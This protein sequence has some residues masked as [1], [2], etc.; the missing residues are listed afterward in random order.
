MPVHWMAPLASMNTQAASSTMVR[1]MTGPANASYLRIISMPK[2]T[3]TSCTIHSDTK[4]IQPSVD[5]PRMELVSSSCSDGTMATS[6][7]RSTTEARKVWMPNQATATAPRSRL[8]SWAP[9]MPKL[10]RLMT[11]KGTPVFWP[12]NP[13]KLSSAKSRTAPMAR[14]ARICQPPRPSEK[15]PTAN[16]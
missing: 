7:T 12:I 16:A 1:R 10:I 2:L 11:G 14:A 3:I 8:A 4:A 6:M 13:E 9:R 15:R 5:R